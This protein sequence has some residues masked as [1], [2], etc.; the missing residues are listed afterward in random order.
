[1]FIPLE[2]VVFVMMFSRSEPVMK[3]SY[4]VGFIS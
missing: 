1:M 3:R 4:S 2:E